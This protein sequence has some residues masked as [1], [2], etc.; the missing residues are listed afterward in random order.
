[1]NIFTVKVNPPSSPAPYWLAFFLLTLIKSISISQVV[2]SNGQEDI[3]EDVVTTD[4]QN[5]EVNTV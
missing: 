3:Q 2:N 1:V 4:E 5:N